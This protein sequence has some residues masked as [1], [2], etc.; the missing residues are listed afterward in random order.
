MDSPY[1][2][3]WWENIEVLLLVNAFGMDQTLGN[4]IFATTYSAAK[5]LSEMEGE[6]GPG[7]R[8]ESHLA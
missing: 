8:K 4:V 7:L 3:P 1:L 2:P 6:K 5:I